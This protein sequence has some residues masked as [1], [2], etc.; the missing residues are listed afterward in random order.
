MKTFTPNLQEQGRCSSGLIGRAWTRTIFSHTS[1]ASLYM[2]HVAM[3]RPSHLSLSCTN[4]PVQFTFLYPVGIPL[5]CSPSSPI[6]PPVHVSLSLYSCATHC[7]VHPRVLYTS[8]LCIIFLKL[9]FA[10]RSLHKL[11]AWH[12]YPHSLPPCRILNVRIG[13]L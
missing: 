11:R 10:G 2:S 1:K 7:P 13:G 8:V 9:C 4:V 3:V 5:F 6:H 12:K